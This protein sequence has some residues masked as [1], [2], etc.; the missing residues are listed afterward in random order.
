MLLQQVLHNLHMTPHGSPM[1]RCILTLQQPLYDERMCLQLQ[2]QVYACV[3][4]TC[5]MEKGL[6][7]L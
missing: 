2:A 6:Q 4:M 7:V 1:Q 5:A 3:W